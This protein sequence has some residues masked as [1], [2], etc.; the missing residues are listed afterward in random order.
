MA[1]YRIEIGGTV[2]NIDAPNKAQ[3]IN[4]AIKDLVKAQVLT[5]RDVAK[6]M[7]AGEV[8]EEVVPEAKEEKQGAQ[9]PVDTVQ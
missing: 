8:F 4:H 2:K 1:I 7:R 9:L 5:P 6:Y 3:A